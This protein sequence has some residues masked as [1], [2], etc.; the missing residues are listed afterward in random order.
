MRKAS[1]TFRTMI[2]AAKRRDTVAGTPAAVIGAVGF[3]VVES[4]A[5]AAVIAV[6]VSFGNDG[7]TGRER[8]EQTD[9]KSDCRPAQE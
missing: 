1:C 8:G 6:A 4:D 7:A 2:A 9:D 5:N 3:V